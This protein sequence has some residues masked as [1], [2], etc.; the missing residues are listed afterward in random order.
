MQLF[1]IIVKLLT[2]SK[3]LHHKCGGFH[4]VYGKNS[5][6]SKKELFVTNVKIFQPLTFVEKKFPLDVVGFLNPIGVYTKI[7]GNCLLPTNWM[8]FLNLS[9]VV[10]KEIQDKVVVLT[11]NENVVI[12]GVLRYCL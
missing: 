4:F 11:V 9:N 1:V 6:T 8:T 10:I 7:T 5:V 12:S 3:E 2:C